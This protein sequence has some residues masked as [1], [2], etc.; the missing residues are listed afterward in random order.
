M[1]LP[2]AFIP[3]LQQGADTTDKVRYITEEETIETG[4]VFF[5]GA[6]HDRQLKLEEVPKKLFSEVM[7]DIDLFISV[8]QAGRPGLP[9]SSLASCSQ[10]GSV[11]R[12][13]GIT[14][15][16]SFAWGAKTP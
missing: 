11:S 1:P 12:A 8:A 7:R 15:G 14:S 2:Q 3:F 5:T 16:R 10:L 4:A 6:R 9:A 13:A